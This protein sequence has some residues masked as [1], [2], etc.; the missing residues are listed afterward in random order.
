[1]AG[2][3][4]TERNKAVI[5]RLP[6]LLDSLDPAAI[7]AV[8][9]EDFVLHESTRP[10]WPHGHE[11]AVRLL[12]MMK[13]LLPDFTLTIE[14]MLAEG[15]K[16]CIRWRYAGTL[17]GSFDGMQGDGSRYEAVALAIY[18]FRDGRIAEDWGTVARLP[19]GHPWRTS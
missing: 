7:K 12:V 8:F 5:R 11:G 15:D 3:A 16:V 13:S 18:R 2:D 6:E 4:E 14:D 10:D 19:D 1:M 17:T 9:T